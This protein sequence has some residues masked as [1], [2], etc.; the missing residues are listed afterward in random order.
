VFVSIFKTTRYHATA[1]EFLGA[2]LSKTVEGKI[3]INNGAVE[4]K[5]LLR[6]LHV[7]LFNPVHRLFCLTSQ[8]EWVE[9]RL[10]KHGQVVS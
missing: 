3:S 4:S 7:L 2:P 9:S 6:T 1:L 8:R 10:L 5:P